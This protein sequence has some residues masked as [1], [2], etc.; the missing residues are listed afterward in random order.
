MTT[1]A[2]YGKQADQPQGQYGR[3]CCLPLALNEGAAL[4]CLALCRVTCFRSMPEG[5]HS[6]AYP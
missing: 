3:R 5:T 1:V 6:D 4:Y 2:M